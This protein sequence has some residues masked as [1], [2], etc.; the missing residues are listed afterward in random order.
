MKRK[1]YK[2]LIV[3]VLALGTTAFAQ[4]QSKKYTETFNVNKDVVVEIEASNAEINVTTWNKNQVY[5]EAVI[6]IEG[7]SKKEAEKYLKNYKF[8]AL[9]NKSKVKVYSRGNHP[10]NFHNDF[11]FFDGDFKMPEIV[12]PDIKIPEMDLNFDFGDIVIPEIDM[13]KI[14]MD[15][16]DIDFDWDEY[17]KNGKDYFFKWKNGVKEVTIKSK[18]DWEKFKKSDE[19]KKWKAEMKSEMDK[20]QKD[21]LKM[22]KNMKFDKEKMKKEMKKAAEEMK[23][24]DMSKIKKDI[25]KMKNDFKNFK[26]DFHFGS[27]NNEFT[28]N[29]KKVKIKKKITIKVPKGATFD[30]NTRHSKV[31][32]PDTNATGKV[33]Y[34]SFDA[35]A[36]NGGDLKIYYSPVNINK[37]NNT[38]LYLNNVTDAKIASVVNSNLTSSS[39]ELKIEKILSNVDIDLSFGDI[40][41]DELSATIGSFVLDLKQSKATIN[42]S[43]FKDELEMNVG[44]DKDS[45][46]KH[47]FDKVTKK[48]NKSHIYGNFSVKTKSEK[49]KIVGKYSDLIMHM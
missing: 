15:I 37:L 3:F 40:I 20:I 47:S 38:K 10:F 30:L 6:E 14:L 13:D 22:T 5:V 4:K 9:G 29:G 42:V 11:V 2:S 48:V 16:E 45:K 18:E 36:L 33:S 26:H 17:K 27:N 32:L 24:I 7:L 49:L 12:I 44:G 8:E 35:I 31:K 39:G 41:I 19:Y 28:I 43:D 23:K 1:L 21:V 34:G 25:A 46:V